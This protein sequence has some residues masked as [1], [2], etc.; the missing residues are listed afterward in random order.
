[1]ENHTQSTSLPPSLIQADELA[2][3]NCGD[4]LTG[5]ADLMRQAAEGPNGPHL[6]VNGF[7]LAAMITLI[8]QENTRAASGWRIVN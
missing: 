3:G 8:S 1:M 7:H 5:L 4:A 2:L 6:E